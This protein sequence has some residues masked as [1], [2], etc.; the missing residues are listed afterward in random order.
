MLE[1]A[2]T[3]RDEPSLRWLIVGD[4]RAAAWVREEIARR[5]LQDRVIMLGR[6]PIERMPSFFRAAN[7][8]L[9]TLK[10]GPGFDMTIP[11]KV[12]SYLATGLP[13]LGMLNG[14]GAAVIE[15]AGA[16]LVCQ[17]GASQELAR[18][19]RLLMELPADLRAVMGERG[20]LYCQREF[21][22]TGLV[23]SLELWMTELVAQSA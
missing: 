7:A 11:G 6:Y 17:A 1:A 21:D 19:V 15:Q 23:S 8:L 2:H 14:E 4:G 18:K 10:Q 13:I 12:Q 16:G 20:R 5:G 9:V 3:L 22:R